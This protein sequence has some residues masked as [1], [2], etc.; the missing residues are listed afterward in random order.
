MVNTEEEEINNSEQSIFQAAEIIWNRK[1]NYEYTIDG[2][3]FT[4]MNTG[5]G[6]D[7]VGK[8]NELGRKFTWERS[9]KWKPPQYNTIDFLISIQKDKYGKDIIRNKVILDDKGEISSILQYKTLILKC[10]FN[11]KV[12]KYV[13][14]FSDVLFNRTS[15]KKNRSF[16]YEGDEDINNDVELGFISGKGY[17]PVPFQPTSPYDKDACFCNIILEDQTIMR[18]EEKDIFQDDMII[19]FSYNTNMKETETAWK[20]VPLRVRY[21]KTSELRANKNNFGNNFSVANDN[22]HSIHFPITEKMIIGQEIP[23]ASDLDDTI[24]YNRKDK[25]S[26]E[27]QAL[28]DF[29]NLFVKRYVINKIS[30]YLHDKMHISSILLIDYA[31]GKCG[32]LPKWIQA[33]IQFVFGV[34]ISK[35]NIMNA[36]DGACVRYLNKKKENPSLKI[37]AVFLN[38]NSGQNIFST[39]KAFYTEQEKEV[40]KAIFGQGGIDSAKNIAKEYVGIGRDGFHISSC[41]FAMHYFFENNKSL[42]SFLRNLTECTRVGGFFIGT[43]YDGKRVFELLRDKLKG[44]SIRLDKNGKKIFEITKEYSNQFDHLPDNDQSIGLPIYVY[45]ESID[46]TF[47]EYLVNFTYFNRLMEDYGF[48]SLSK[49]ENDLIGFHDSNGS[50]EQL[51]RLMEKETRNTRDKKYGKSLEMT[52]EERTIS[53][54]NRY[55]VYKKVRAISPDRIQKMYNKHVGKE[56]NASYHSDSDSDVDIEKSK[57]IQKSV[58]KKIPD[59]KIILSLRNFVPIKENEKEEEVKEN[60]KEEEE[61]GKEEEVKEGKEEGKEEEEEKIYGEYQDLFDK[62]TEPMKEKIQKYTTEKQIE[63]LKK[64]RN[65]SNKKIVVAK[66]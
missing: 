58:I 30:E 36:K 32:D 13:N 34:D 51:F 42:H 16:E 29:H 33:N 22:W 55:F 21:D 4:P 43:C 40:A 63:I 38:G 20:W 7:K 9:F 15:N 65:Q 14:A 59:K 27:T 6:S 17:Q 19:E 31:V 44:Q 64:L 39:Q 53:F 28:K 12:H 18:T 61:E 50:F 24:Y 8:A 54:L 47:M 48:V 37:K 26:V 10:G 23:T 56:E 57:E 52:K 49:D 1:D 41:Q 46:K 25:D 60:E 2:L 5:V 45:Q 11:E 3:I 62:L 66:K 35:D